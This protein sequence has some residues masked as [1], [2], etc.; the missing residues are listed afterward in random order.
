MCSVVK[1]N[2]VSNFLIYIAP[3]SNV[4]RKNVD[5]IGWGLLLWKLKNL[6]NTTELIAALRL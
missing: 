1:K 6:R 2:I 4:A 5:G 3:I